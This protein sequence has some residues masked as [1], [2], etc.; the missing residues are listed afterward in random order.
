MSRRTDL[1]IDR[2]NLDDELVRQPQLYMDWALKAAVA[3][4]EKTEAKDRLEIVKADMDGKVRTD[5]EKYNI[6]EGK[7]SEGAIKAVIAQHS[8]VKRYNRIYIKALKNEKFLNETKIA[9][10]HRKK[11]LE[12]LVSLNIQL[13]FAEPRVPVEGR[14][15]MHQSRKSAI[16]KE[17]KRKRKIKRR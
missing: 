9:F 1:K 4:I 8:K 12:A 6:P 13:H 15:I 14:E 17:L 3:S 16:L 2:Y 7:A 10:T 5:P 11:M